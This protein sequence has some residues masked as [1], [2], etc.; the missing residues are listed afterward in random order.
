VHPHP[1]AGRL[2]EL[3]ERVV[4]GQRQVVLGAE[5]LVE[6]TLEAGV[7]GE[8]PAPRRDARIARRHVAARGG[9]AGSHGVALYPRDRCRRNDPFGRRS[10][11]VGPGL[12]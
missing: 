10:G 2:G 6:Q 1:A 11:A 12:R 4:L 7:G 5:L 8:E 3:E 9:E